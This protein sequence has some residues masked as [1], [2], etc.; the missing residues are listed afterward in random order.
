VSRKWC[1]IDC[2]GDAGS[3]GLL[4]AAFYSDQGGVYQQ[5]T[6]QIVCELVHYAEEGYTF[7]A[8][9][10]EYELGV[11]FHQLGLAMAGTYFNGIF[12]YGSWKHDRGRPAAEL[13]DSAAMT[14]VRRLEDLGAGIGL[15]KLPTPQTLRGIDPDQYE[16]R[17]EK[18]ERWECVECYAI[19]DAEIVYSAVREIHTLCGG[20]GVD[21]GRSIPSMAMSLWRAIDDPSPCSLRDRK[22]RELSRDCYLGG[23]TEAYKLGSISPCY[24]ADM[25]SMYGAVMLD[26]PYPDPARLMY[27]SDVP[28]TEQLASC[29]GVVEATVRVPAM[30]AP[31]LPHTHNGVRSYPVGEITGC[32]PL[33]ELRYGVSLGCDVVRVHRAAFSR[34][35]LQPFSRYVSTLWELR[36]AYAGKDHVYELLAKQLLTNLYGR[37]GMREELPKRTIRPLTGKWCPAKTLGANHYIR[38]GKRWVDRSTELHC[39]NPYANAMWA[40]QTTGEARIRLHKHMLNQGDA[41][42]YVDTDSV[43]ASQPLVGLSDGLGGLRSTG[44]YQRAVIAGPKFYALEDSFGTWTARARG[45]PREH[46]LRYLREGYATYKKPLTP[47]E[48]QRQ[49]GTAGAWIEITRHHMARPLARAPI[50]P[51]RLELEYGWSDTVAPFIR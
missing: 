20:W 40:A 34:F 11:I 21:V 14:G 39:N 9:N 43:F 45:I 3:R 46:A 37:I 2:E 27:L 25:S 24:T 42:V 19:R 26:T 33:R 22:I 23:R 7:V 12:S 48:A 5:H 17:C 50:N 31:P 36:Q 10:A 8:H 15:P 51:E 16:W 49:G 28:W 35:S 44:D 41:L 47:F 30:L 13:W 32:W 38:G 1:A 6:E 18:H 29:E 4:G